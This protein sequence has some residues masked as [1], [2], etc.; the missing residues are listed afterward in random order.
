[1]TERGPGASNGIVWLFA[2]TLFVG[3]LLM[4][5]IEPMAAKAVLPVLGGTPMVWNTC[6]LFFQVMLLGGYAYAHGAQR[7]LGSRRSIAIY[8]ALLAV[9]LATLPFAIG[10]N[11]A[12]PAGNNPIGWLLLVLVTSIGLPFFA[13]SATT[14]VLQHWFA[15]TDHPSAKDPYFLYAASNLGS[16]LA[17]V[18]Y[19][20]IIEPTLRLRTQ[21]A[22]WSIG[23]AML[24][25]L[26][27]LSVVAG[28]RRSAR[29]VPRARADRDGDAANVAPLPWARRAS[30]MAL[31]FIPSSLMLAVT[32]YFSTDLAP[33]PLFWIVPLALYLLTFAIAFGTRLSFLRSIADRFMPILIL[34]LVMLMIANAF[35]PLGLAIP[36]HLL[37]FATAALVCHG[38]LAADRPEPAHLTE[39]YFWIAFG[40]MLGG[41]F[42]TLVAPL[43][44]R[45][46]IEYPLVLVLACAAR[47][48]RRSEA[49]PSAS[50][51]DLV[52]PAGVGAIAALFI[53]WSRP[54]RD[55]AQLFLTGLA[56]PAVLAFT[57][58]GAPVRFAAIVATMLVAGS[59]AANAPGQ[60]IYR[61]RT[62]FGIYRVTADAV[63]H[64][65][66]HGTTEHGMQAIDAARQHEA[67]T[68]YHRD[69]P[70]GQVF[71]E[72]P[73]A[74]TG[75]D[76]AVVGLGI[77][78]LASYRVPGQQ[79]TFYEIDPEVERIARTA[80]FFTHL[81]ACGDGCRVVLGDARLSLAR[82]PEHEYGLIVLDAF[83]SDAIPVHLLT[84]EA[85]TL[86]LSRLA[87]GGALAFHISNRHMAL[88]PVLARVA[89][90]H[91]LAVRME[92]HA[93]DQ[94]VTPERFS[95]EWMV[96]ARHEGDLGSLIADAR[97]TPPS[98]SPSTPL[99]TDDF[100]NILSVLS[101]RIR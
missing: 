71:A 79:W 9:S 8:L 49:G 76:V 67:L 22:G 72:L 30:W 61:S 84:S 86:Y 34:P 87:R 26:A 7:W 45:S 23:F 89:L 10:R 31:A 68:Y 78:S 88:G 43:V 42:N 5:T 64:S 59:L 81:Q 21:R 46:V 27:C 75:R 95:S 97:W 85:L 40:G 91:G 41:V 92:R 74:A 55:S 36:L 44:F 1:M 19:P 18:M 35:V 77:G 17:L 28:W 25:V 50:W 13:L 58:S 66:F 20:T 65:L 4:F 3:S 63:D 47:L 14:S 32:T 6:V 94:A 90:G 83:S 54:G 99:W 2:T 57:Q 100:S 96:M 11:A 29:D 16:L 82:A 73:A 62:F 98:I 101:L 48:G 70:I 12:P 51:N 60:T 80:A 93:V 52:V 33:V 53:V 56:V 15:G 37:V 24:V 69:G 39:F 38:R